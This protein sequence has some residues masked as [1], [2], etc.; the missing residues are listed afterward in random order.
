MEG[1]GEIKIWWE[2]RE[3]TR[4]RVFPD[5][6]CGMSKFLADGEGLSSIPTSRE[7]PALYHFYIY[8]SVSFFL[9]CDKRFQRN[10]SLQHWVQACT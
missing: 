1:K 6:G 7:N 3:S 9:A 8:L 2:E 5:V 4:G 10:D